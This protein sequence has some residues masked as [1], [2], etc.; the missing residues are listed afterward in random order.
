P[1]KKGETIVIEGSEG[2]AFEIC[3]AFRRMAVM[4]RVFFIH[5]AYLPASHLSGRL[6]G[7]LSALADK[8]ANFKGLFRRALF[9]SGLPEPFL[10]NRLNPFKSRIH[11]RL[12]PLVHGLHFRLNLRVRLNPFPNLTHVRLFLPLTFMIF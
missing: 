9:L 12:N 5:T 2:D 3:V 11:L 7:S 4:I 6:A 1:A 8:T 10:R